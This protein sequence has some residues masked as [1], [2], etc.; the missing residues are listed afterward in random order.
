MSSESYF[1]LITCV[2]VLFM[3]CRRMK[4]VRFRTVPIWLHHTVSK[5]TCSLNKQRSTKQHLNKWFGSRIPLLNFLYKAR[6]F[7]ICKYQ[8]IKCPKLPQRL[9][10]FSRQDR[11]W[12]AEPSLRIIWNCWQTRNSS[13]FLE[14]M[15]PGSSLIRIL[16]LVHYF[17]LN[18]KSCE[19]VPHSR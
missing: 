16:F 19:R 3:S 15:T 1:L 14:K 5:G 4:I 11:L 8:I 2:N 10:D 9:W 17:L 6:F 12:G 7:F 13:N 18:N